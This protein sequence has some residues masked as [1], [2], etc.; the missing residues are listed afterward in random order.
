MKTFIELAK[1]QGYK[2][3]KHVR[4]WKV[5]F[6]LNFNLALKQYLQSHESP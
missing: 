6:A 2:K 1:N 4:R 3:M 5:Y